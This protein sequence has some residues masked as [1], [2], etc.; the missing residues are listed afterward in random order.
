MSFTDTHILSLYS[1]NDLFYEFVTLIQFFTIPSD[2]SPVQPGIP[3]LCLTHEGFKDERFMCAEVIKLGVDPITGATSMRLL[4]G[5]T[6]GMDLEI[7]C[8]DLLLGQPRGRE[9]LPLSV[10]DMP[11]NNIRIPIE[12]VKTSRYAACT[13]YLDVGGLTELRGFYR[14]KPDQ[15]SSELMESQQVIKFSIDTRQDP[16]AVTWSEIG[17]AEWRDAADPEVDKTMKG[18]VFDGLRGRLCY[19]HPEVKDEMVV[20]EID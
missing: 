12:G 14:G 10:Y 20:V 1:H 11:V 17:P 13:R 7:H 15:K 2:G 19:V 4:E 16:W 8:V 3:T 6:S 9:V 18:I 5:R